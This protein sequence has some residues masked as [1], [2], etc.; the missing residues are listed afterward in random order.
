MST[1]VLYHGFGVRGD[2][3]EKTEVVEGRLVIR[4]SQSKESCRCSACGSRVL[5]E[6]TPLRPIVNCEALDPRP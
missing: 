6:P 4:L 3:Q 1:V 2:R 5:T